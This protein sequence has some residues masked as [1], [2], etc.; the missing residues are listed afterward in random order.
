MS[1]IKIEKNIPIPVKQTGISAVLR[2]L[3]IGDS[4]LAKKGQQAHITASGRRVGVKVVSRTVATD[5]IR[6]WRVE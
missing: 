3:D 1:E 4:F 6:V 2:S 5:Q